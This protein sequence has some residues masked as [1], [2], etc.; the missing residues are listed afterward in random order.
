MEYQTLGAPPEHWSYLLYGPSKNGKTTFSA[1][2]P[3]PL[4][5]ATEPGSIGGLASIRKLNHPYVKIDNWS[6]VTPLITKLKRKD[7]NIETVV[8]SSLTYLSR[9]CMVD[10]LKDSNREV[11]VIHDWMLNADKT[12]NVVVRACELPY[13]QIF[14]C[15][16][17]IVTIKG[18]SRELN[19]I[20]PDLPGRLARDMPAIIDEVFYIFRERYRDKEAKE[21]KQRVM[22]LTVPDP[23]RGVVI[24]GDRSTN[25]DMLEE[26]DYEKLIK[27]IN[28]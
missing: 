18:P 3:K 11:P 24:A 27:K 21:F 16:D 1:Q 28:S 23:A 12:R 19:Q 13:T 14:E 5:I 9:L 26:A 20:D 10:I 2:W 7:P 17:H 15:N 22:L 25:L 4:F 6:E 8:W